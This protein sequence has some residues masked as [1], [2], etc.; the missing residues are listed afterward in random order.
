VKCSARRPTCRG[1]FQSVRRWPAHIGQSWKARLA[2]DIV[3]GVGSS[4]MGH[5][6]VINM[7]DAVDND[8]SGVGR[9]VVLKADA[10]DRRSREAFDPTMEISPLD[11]IRRQPAEDGDR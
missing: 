10:G 9:F 1:F 2:L 11:R 5:L 7:P 6:F 3:N 8:A 4:E